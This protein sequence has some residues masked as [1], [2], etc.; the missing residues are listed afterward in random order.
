MGAKTPIKSI[1]HKHNCLRK[2]KFAPKKEHK[3]IK[4]KSRMGTGLATACRVQLANAVNYRW[5]HLPR[6]PTLY[7]STGSVAATFMEF[8]VC[9][10]PKAVT[11]IAN[12]CV[13]SSARM[14]V[15]MWLCMYVCMYV[16]M[17]GHN[18]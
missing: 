17:Y 13:K 6:L 18:I 12:G 5:K 15:C 3:K 9:R 11:T 7:K 8:V 1:I 10:T 2:H 14:Y 4:I 16:C